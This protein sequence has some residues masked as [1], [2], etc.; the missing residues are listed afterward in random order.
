[1]EQFLK[2]KQISTRLLK[3]QFVLI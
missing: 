3:N 1:M 2:V